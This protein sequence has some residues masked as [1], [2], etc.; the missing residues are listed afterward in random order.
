MQ[1][2][3]I[4]DA[5][6]E[7]SA[8]NNLDDLSPLFQDM[9]SQVSKTN[10]QIHLTTEEFSIYP[11]TISDELWS[12]EDGGVSGSCSP[13]SSSSSWSSFN[14]YLWFVWWTVFTDGDFWKCSWVHRWCCLRTQRPQTS[15]SDLCPCP[16]CTDTPDCLN[17]LMIS[18][19]VDDEIFKVFKGNFI[20]RIIFLKLFHNLFFNNCLH[21][22]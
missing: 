4:R 8:D 12:R 18:C 15:S 16:T 6:V 14:L 22:Y 11:Q 2:H 13:V 10:V 20:L 7:L 1:P 17:L 19:T 9:V 21:I 5:A 3:T